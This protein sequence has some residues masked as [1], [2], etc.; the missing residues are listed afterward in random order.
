MV[1]DK[2]EPGLSIEILQT[3]RGFGACSSEKSLEFEHHSLRLVGIFP[4]VKLSLVLRRNTK[5]LT[6]GGGSSPSRQ[7]AVAPSTA[8][9]LTPPWR[10]QN[11]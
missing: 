8:P 5:F 11:W 6:T 9:S 10:R 3:G 2:C 1:Y 4:L 7:G